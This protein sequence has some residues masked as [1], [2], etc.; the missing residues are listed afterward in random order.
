MKVI[1]LNDV[2][3]VGKKDEI[4]EVADG[5]AENFLIRR[6]LAVAYTKA[7]VS[8]L[9]REK[10]EEAKKEAEAV[11][12]A[13]VLKTKVEGLSLVFPVKT[14]EEDKV[15]GSVSTKQIAD[16]LN[17]QYGISVDKRKF[18]D[19]DNLV[20]LGY[21]HVRIELHKG[22]VAQLKVQLVSAK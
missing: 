12:Q 21:H 6:K 4:K 18:I 5:Y 11:A 16:V 17:K 7:S 22:V 1:L 9:N 2:K 14:G 19:N 10:A 8:N 3:G 15:F 13:K 20:T